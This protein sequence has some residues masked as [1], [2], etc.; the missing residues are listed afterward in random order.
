M[1]RHCSEKTRRD[2]SLSTCICYVPGTVHVKHAPTSWSYM[3]VGKQR[4]S[5][6]T[7]RHLH[8]NVV[9]KEVKERGRCEGREE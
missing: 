7:Q 4:V 2:A 9:L 1:K 5:K 6:S 8:A 3:L